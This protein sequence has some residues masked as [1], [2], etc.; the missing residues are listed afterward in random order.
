MPIDLAPTE[1]SE[2]VKQPTT[3]EEATDNAR[4]QIVSQLQ[5]QETPKEP[6]PI[7]PETPKES[8][9]PKEPETLTVDPDD[10]EWGKDE[11]GNFIFKIDPEDPRSTVYKGKTKKEALEHARTGWKAKDSYIRELK[12]KAL[13]PERR[14]TDEHQIVPPDKN[15]ILAETFKNA[16]VD[17]A[18]LTWTADQWREYESQVPGVMASDAYQTVKGLQALAN[19]RFNKE[20][21]SFTND[22]NLD[23]E[24]DQ[25]K[26]L[27]REYDILMEP[28]EAKEWYGN[29][30][31]EIDKD[32]INF[33]RFGRRKP[34]VIVTRVSKELRKLERPRVEKELK[35]KKDVEDAKSRLDKTKAST[36]GKTVTKPTMKTE[37]SPTSFDEARDRV[38]RDWG[39]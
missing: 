6:E 37:K 9:P 20:F 28:E 25:V 34:G 26:Q 24:T 1:P 21:V 3:I 35:T 22:E 33:D 5:E 13:S 19:E 2:P 11:D 10:I 18:M 8:E 12:S 36:L 38:L 17:I 30:L 15:K 4:N 7:E 29:I 27:V 23:V 39:K 32:P 14:Q 16:N 31:D